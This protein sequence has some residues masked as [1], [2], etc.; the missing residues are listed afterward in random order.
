MDKIRKKS[1]RA[2]TIPLDE[3]VD[4]VLL[5][6]KKERLHATPSDVFAQ[7]IGY[8]GANSG[9]ALSTIASL[10]YYGLII[11]PKEGFL[12]VSKE[13]EKYQF[14]PDESQ[15][16]ECLIRFLKTPQL[17]ADMLDQYQDALPSDAN[18]KFELIQRG[19]SPA[20][21]DT[22]LVA[23]RKSVDFAR[24]YDS[25]EVAF[26]NKV[27][28]ILAGEEGDLTAEPVLPVAEKTKDSAGHALVSSNKINN[29]FDEIPVRL[30]GGRRAI[31]RIPSPFYSADKT[32]LKAQIDLLLAEDE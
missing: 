3:A 21:A 17:F 16:Q 20:A 5:A 1:P 10:K 6:Y 18:L 15:K 28:S 4:R 25:E 9:A 14:L 22:V 32:R 26:Q 31:L 2:P 19:F 12:A 30:P 23:F 7:N 13:V 24:Y 27:V 11:R 8:K 29:D